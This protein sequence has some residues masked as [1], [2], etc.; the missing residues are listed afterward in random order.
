MTFEQVLVF[1]KIVQLGSFKAA[2]GELHKTQPAISHAIKK[3]EEE[4]EVELFDRSGYRPILTDHGKAFFERS[5]KIL[6]G[7]Q[8]L[9]SMA[10]S[11]RNREEPEIRLA[12]DGISPLPE[13]LKLF[14]K[15][16][17][18]YPSTKLNMGFDIL[19]EAER[20][21]L[22]REAEIGITHFISETSVLDVIPITHVRM[23]P[24][25]SRDLL[26]EKAVTNQAQ[27]LE[28]EQIVVK[29]KA[30]ARGINFGLLDGGKKWR[31]S[32]SNFKRE[33]II[34]GMGWGHLPEHSIHQELKEGQLVP[35][36]FEDIYPRE[37]VINLIRLKKHQFGVVARSLWDELAA[38]H[39]G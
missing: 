35:L 2:S 13:L 22:D 32:D 39:Q 16:N 12:V 30:G 14:R 26:K 33:I 11:F 36:H 6:Q 23:V 21:V 8:E 1:H 29:D 38:L 15:F 34:A 28:I 5:I 25:M 9:E 4:M 27:L 18:R 3:L 10:N 17:E 7:M 24:V 31:L 19:S 37:L 20:R